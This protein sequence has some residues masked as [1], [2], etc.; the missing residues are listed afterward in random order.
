MVAVKV[1]PG[2][3]VTQAMLKTSDSGE[4]VTL[5]GLVSSVV[6]PAGALPLTK[7]C[8]WLLLQ[9]RLNVEVTLLQ[10]T[11]VPIQGLLP[12]IVNDPAAPAE[13]VT[14]RVKGI[15]TPGQQAV[16]TPP[17]LDE[18]EGDDDGEA[19]GLPDGE[20]LGK[21]LGLPGADGE[22]LGETLGLPG[23]E[24]A[25]DG[26]LTSADDTADGGILGEDT[27]DGGILGETLLEGP[28]GV[29]TQQGMQTASSGRPR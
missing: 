9:R 11:A 25:L 21:A 22:T 6:Q 3:P 7:S 24:R 20:A 19:L 16:K 13:S 1:V 15:S 29:G 27:A 2:Q 26:L 4:Q 17:G 8:H 18:L 23:A 12:V 5:V 28:K 10:T 14:W